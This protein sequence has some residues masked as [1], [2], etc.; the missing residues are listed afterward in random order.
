MIRGA[1]AARCSV[2]LVFKS[3]MVPILR[4]NPEAMT[5][6]ECS[7]HHRDLS[8]LFGIMRPE[9]PT[10]DASAGAH[11]RTRQSQAAV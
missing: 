1:R 2:Q 5:A 3:F 8:D 4:Q 11:N 10:R 7:H 6:D 9:K